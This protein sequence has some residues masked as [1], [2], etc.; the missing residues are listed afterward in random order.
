MRSQARKASRESRLTQNNPMDKFDCK[1]R[2]TL[3]STT[4]S[5]LLGIY[6]LTLSLGLTLCV[7]GC[8]SGNPNEREFLNNAPPGTPSEFPNESVAQRKART[9]SL[10]K[11]E[12]E[13]EARNQKA[14]AEKDKMP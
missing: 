7:P 2:G 13:I 10:S 4:K 3:M 9:R 6:L 1:I 5:G 14:Q 11:P 8:G 12:K